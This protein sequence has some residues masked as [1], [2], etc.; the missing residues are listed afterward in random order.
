MILVA[1]CSGCHGALIEA[2][3]AGR[4]ATL[5]KKRQKEKSAPL[6][7]MAGASVPRSS[8]GLC[9]IVELQMGHAHEFHPLWGAVT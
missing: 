3:P 8:L 2:E 6:G 1:V 9:N 4:P 5:C 7:A